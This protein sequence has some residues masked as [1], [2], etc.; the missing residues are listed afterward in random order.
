MADMLRRFLTATHDG[1]EV[2]DDPAAPYFGAVLA[3]TSLIPVD[4][5]ERIG[6]LSFDDWRQPTP[7]T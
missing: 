6:R 7:N 1:R 2:I 5:T 3:E 4:G